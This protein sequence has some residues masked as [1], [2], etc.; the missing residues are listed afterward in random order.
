[1][2]TNSGPALTRPESLGKKLRNAAVGILFALVLLIPRILHLRRNPRSWRLF[3]ILLGIAGA[4]LVILPL[5]LG[6]NYAYALIGMVMFIAAI[7]LPPAKPVF[8][9]DDKA[10]NSV[11][12]SS[13]TV[14]NTNPGALPLHPSSFL[15]ARR[16]FRCSTLAS[17][18]SWSFLSLRSH[19]PVRNNLEKIGSFA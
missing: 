16:V 9:V 4:A 6:N 1:M 7:L 12:W 3:C 11:P 8:N 10:A 17:N 14:G 2:S 13:S 19:W 5:G 15:S 18:R